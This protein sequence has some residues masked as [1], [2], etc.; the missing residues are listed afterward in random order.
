M[1]RELRQF[2]REEAATSHFGRYRATRA[3]MCGRATVVAS[4]C[5]T[6]VVALLNLWFGAPLA[7]AAA[8]SAPH[9]IASAGDPGLITTET[10]GALEATVGGNRP[11]R[12]T[13]TPAALGRGRLVPLGEPRG[14]RGYARLYDGGL[15]SVWYSHRSRGTEQGF[16][17]ARRPVGSGRAVTIAM[18][19]SGGLSPHLTASDN[20]S[21]LGPDGRTDLTYSGLQVMDA[22]GIRLPAHLETS[23]STIRI[24]YDDQHATY[25]VVVDPW[26]QVAGLNAPPGASVF[27][28]VIASSSNGSTVLVGDP[29]GGTGNAGQVTAYSFN[30]TSWSAGTSLVRPAGSV[31]FGTS[32]ALS[33]NG[34]TAMVGDPSNGASG[35]VSVYTFNGSTWSADAPLTPPDTAAYFGT[36]VALSADGTTALVGDP[37]GGIAY[38]GAATIYTFS[39]GAWNEGPS[40]RTYDTSRAFGSSV[41]LSSNGQTAIVGDPN[42]GATGHGIVY[43]YTGS[44]WSVVTAMAPTGHP[45]VYGTSVA[46][47]GSGTAAVVGDPGSAGVGAATIETL[48]GST[49]QA[50][51]LPL[52]AGSA[53]FG[54]SVSIN[55]S[56]TVALVGDALAGGTGS[57][58]V[59][60]KSGSSWSAAPMLAAP[61]GAENFGTSVVISNDGS[62][63]FVGDP[64]GGPT[65]TG[66]VTTYASHGT[67]WSL[68]TATA[69][70]ANSF[71]FG[72]SVA[73][74]E[75]GGT[76]IG[77]DPGDGSI[78][79]GQATV[80]SDTGGNLSGGTPLVAAPSSSA[81]GTS[82]ALSG[83]GRTAL[84]G[85]PMDDY[86]GAATVYTFNGTS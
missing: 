78:P 59:F 57:T 85:D 28:T 58:S 70:P 72:T 47:S 19:T 43:S 10:T 42:G 38:T 30:G 17:V 32:V 51:A 14:H 54:T 31:A 46:L 52:P 76:L 44:S 21:L 45:I 40:L 80:F 67:A 11:V 6:L 60:D 71:S 64:G 86:I 66:T 7:S 49:W 15:L 37:G 83:N 29:N 62:T 16:T 22:R 65:E 35:T 13:L 8:A 26:I 5:V 56:G 68:G 36:S 2:A 34:S 27:G 4:L 41:A 20:V 48:S 12:W 9:R 55:A 61:I 81:F 50:S 73:I 74:S 23:G 1:H 82:V 63:A 77:G 69:T 24:T 25:P 33:G 39:G 18:T 3:A 84:V 79:G 53:A 75:D